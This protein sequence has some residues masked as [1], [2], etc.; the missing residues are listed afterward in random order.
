MNLT[1]LFE[2]QKVLDAVITVKRNLSET[3]NLGWKVNALY[4]ELGELL[5]EW[6][7]FKK[8]SKNQDPRTKVELICSPCRGTGDSNSE[9][10]AESMMEGAGGVP[11]EKCEECDGTGKDG[12]KN[13]LL[14]EYVDGLSFILSIGN[15][16]E[17]H[18]LDVHG[19][20]SESPNFNIGT[21]TKKTDAGDQFRKAFRMT[22][23]FDMSP[24]IE[25]YVRVLSEFM[26]LGD[27]LGFTEEQIEAA[28]YA[29]NEI[30]HERQR[31]G[32]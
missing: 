20:Y 28:Y 10:H 16:L 27:A 25:G 13:L 31:S 7:G 12:Y 23:L 24:G 21:R 29:K 6:R 15:E 30:N 26:T 14:E 11:Y 17:A 8:W 9:A 18:G 4:A 19:Y 3:G 1:K 22:A 32:Y 2:M 5:N